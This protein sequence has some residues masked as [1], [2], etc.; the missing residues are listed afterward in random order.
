MTG[1]EASVAN[2]CYDNYSQY[3]IDKESNILID[4]D[5]AVYFLKLV[6][7]S[8]GFRGYCSSMDLVYDFNSQ[9]A[10]NLNGPMDLTVTYKKTTEGYLS[11]INFQTSTY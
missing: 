8:G 1:T 6:P 3:I 4:A 9:W 5:N 10:L 2:L 7:D 11:G